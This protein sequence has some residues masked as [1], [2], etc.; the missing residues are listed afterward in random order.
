MYV[1]AGPSPTSCLGLTTGLWL[2]IPVLLSSFPP[3]GG[4]YTYLSGTSM[5]T[6]LVTAAAAL[7]AS[8]LGASNGSY[9]QADTIKAI[10]MS[11]GKC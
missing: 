10:L 8:V 9:R 11:T 2:L 4:N 1:S 5:S 6:P 3:A 7:V